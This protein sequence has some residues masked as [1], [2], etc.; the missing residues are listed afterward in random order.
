MWRGFS[1][2]RVPDL[3]DRVRRAER[4]LFRHRRAKKLLRSAQ[5]LFRGK[6]YS[7]ACVSWIASETGQ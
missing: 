5:I 1:P 7:R 3:E 4:R 6:P 2:V